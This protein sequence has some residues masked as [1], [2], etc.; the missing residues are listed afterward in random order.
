RIHSRN[1]LKYG[2]FDHKDNF[3]RYVND[4]KLL[5]Y[6]ELIVSSLGE[7]LARF[8]NTDEIFTP[9]EIVTG[10]MN[11]PLHR[12]NILNKDYTHMGVGVVNHKGFLLVSQTFAN[13]LVKRITPIPKKIKKK[14]KLTLQFEYMSPIEPGKLNASLRVPNKELRHQVAKN[15]FTIGSMPAQINW[16]D[17]KHMYVELSFVAGKGDYE[18]SFGYGGGFYEQGVKLKVK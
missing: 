10:W 11:S 14:A 15:A 17:A 12:E 8:Y 7:N 9:E 6:P 18:L 2:F 5:Y 13:A 16:I 3:G 4:R 1:M